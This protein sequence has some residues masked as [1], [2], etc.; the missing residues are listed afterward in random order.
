MLSHA[1]MCV[2]Y[3]SKCLFLVD[4]FVMGPLNL[5]RL[6]CLQHF[7]TFLQFIYIIF[8]CYTFANA[9]LAGD[10]KSKRQR[11]KYL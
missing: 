8:K 6:H 4:H 10:T 9:K 11:N 5:I 7:L 3:C 1:A 2:S